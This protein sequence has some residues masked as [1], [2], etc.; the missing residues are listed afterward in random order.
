MAGLL[1]TTLWKYLAHQIAGLSVNR[2]VI[3]EKKT[4][5][6]YKGKKKES[7]GV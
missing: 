1:R 5:T 7:E 3:P 6:K 4:F 2:K